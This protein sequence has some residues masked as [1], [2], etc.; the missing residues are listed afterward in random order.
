MGRFDRW[1]LFRP[2]SSAQVASALLRI[3]LLLL[4]A[5]PLCQCS[6][7]TGPEPPPPDDWTAWEEGVPPPSGRTFYLDPEGGALANPGTREQPLPG[8]QAVVEAGLIQRVTAVDHPYVEGAP[9]EVTHPGAPIRPGDI[10]VLQSGDHGVVRLDESHADVFT[11]IRAGEGQRPVLRRL[12]LVGVER[13]RIEGLVVRG[14]NEEGLSGTLV[15][16]QSHGW[17]GPCRY[18]IIESCDLASIEDASTW[19]AADW[20]QRAASG[21][22]ASGDFISIRDNQLL[23][24]N[25]GI[26]VSGRY[27]LVEHNVIENFC[28][29]GL[30]GIG[31][32]MVFD[33]NTVKNC[34][35][36]NDN[37]DDGF[38]SWSINDDP[39]RERIVLRGN[40]IIGYSNPDQPFRGTLQGIGCFDG[41]YV[42]WVIEN[43]VVATDHWHGIT[44]LGARGC[45]VVNNTVVDLNED[46]PG[47]PWVRIGPHKDGRT[48]SGCLIRNNVAASI[49]AAGGVVADHNLES[50]AYAD[51][52]V[53]YGALDLRPR[54]DASIVDA[55]NAQGAPSVD[56]DG[57]P[58]PQGEGVDIG[59]YER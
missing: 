7:T 57:Q 4:L 54:A 49:Q 50:T 39:P 37:H 16:V 46:D 2:V 36:V 23:N 15:D 14:A 56:I 52:F 35:D 11:T 18:V 12:E 6:D 31:S 26:S 45:R 21:I 10:L 34:Y 30:R 41:M 42:D 47:P 3:A 38:Q 13:Y 8:L 55:G 25:F 20:D 28:G 19:S 51:L 44:L 59:A 22:G 24:V 5:L 48:S 53:D 58:R 32:D 17:A 29:D 27:A 43:N 33:H 9:L 1:D 40:V